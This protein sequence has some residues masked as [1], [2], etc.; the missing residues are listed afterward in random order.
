M[1]TYE[2]RC[3]CGETMRMDGATKEEAANTLLSNFMTPEAVKAHMAEKHPGEPVPSQDQVR[4]GLLAT[5][6]PV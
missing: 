3:S 6:T 1:A 2:M 4:Q 5:A